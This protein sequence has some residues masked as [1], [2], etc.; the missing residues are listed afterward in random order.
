MRNNPVNA[1]A[2]NT[3]HVDIAELIEEIPIDVG[4]WVGRE[5]P[6]PQSATSLL[7]PNGIVAR[8]YINEDQGVIATLMIVQCR[9]A[10]D[11]GGHYPPVCYPANGWT[12]NTDDQNQTFTIGDQS[13]QVYGFSRTAGRE[14]R[15]IFIYSLFAFPRVC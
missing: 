5:V 8:Q 6:L 4:D 14:E 13:L 7:N 10:R 11:M 9:D 3:Y 2:I 15:E 1:E 12:D